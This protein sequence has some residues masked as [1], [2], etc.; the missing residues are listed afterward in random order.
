MQGA[1]VVLMLTEAGVLSCLAYHS[2]L[3]RCAHD[4]GHDFFA[5]WGLL[6]GLFQGCMAPA[7]ACKL[8]AHVARRFVLVQHIILTDKGEQAWCAIGSLPG[9]Q[10]GSCAHPM[11]DTG[12]G[13]NSHV[14]HL[15]TH[16]KIGVRSF[17]GDMASDW[18]CALTAS[19]WQQR[20]SMTLL[21]C[22]TE[23]LTG[24]RH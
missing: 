18:L 22:L 21:Q 16:S 3:C 19:R 9:A 20:W 8:T 5:L 7:N 23:L 6:S 24:R 1:A 13:E 12:N 14:T 10:Q 17:K 11:T 2:R 4:V 15:Q